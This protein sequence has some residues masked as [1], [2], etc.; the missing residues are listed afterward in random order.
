MDRALREQ[1]GGKIG[2][3]ARLVWATIMALAAGQGGASAAVLGDATWF[4]RDRGADV[5]ERQHQALTA[6]GGGFSIGGFGVRPRLGASLEAVDGDWGGGERSSDLALRLSPGVEAASHWPRHALMFQAEGGLGR[7]AGLE[8]TGAGDPALSDWR[9]GAGGRLDIRR[10]LTATGGVS[11]DRVAA[12]LGEVGA[13]DPSSTVNPTDR[14]QMMQTHLA[15]TGQQAR[16]VWSL[17]ADWREVDYRGVNPAQIRPAQIRDDQQM[18]RLGARAAYALSPSLAL[19]AEASGDE[20]RHEALGG[21]EKSSRGRMALIGVDFEHGGLMRSDLALGGLR[22]SGLG[23]S[24]QDRD[25]WAGRARLDW[26]VTPLT[27]VRLSGS[28]TAEDGSGDDPRVLGSTAALV[29]AVEVRVDHELLRD[30]VLSGRVAGARHVFDV[31]EEREG[32]KLGPD[33]RLD[34]FTAALSA[35]RM[36]SRRAAVTLALDHLSQKSRS[37]ERRSLDRFSVNRLSLSVTR[38]F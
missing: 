3:A 27:T 32:E 10:G 5:R 29:S 24:E 20:R 14:Y 33:Q 38:R 15:V 13:F 19:Y 34:R 7:R 26:F 2:Q 37:L 25:G 11:L 35:T 1:A 12:S 23:G 28:R 21:W 22:R 8:R 4:T 9:L 31:D 30:L 36:L 18:L 16:M 6:D 17:K